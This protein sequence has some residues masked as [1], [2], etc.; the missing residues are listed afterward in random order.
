[1]YLA[2]RE[3]I[4]SAA[5][6]FFGSL[7]YAAIFIA[8]VGGIAWFLIDDK[9]FTTTIAVS[10]TILCIVSAAFKLTDDINRSRIGAHICE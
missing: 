3:A 2:K 5:R 4:W 9:E 7:V 6:S 10:L 1:M 8:L